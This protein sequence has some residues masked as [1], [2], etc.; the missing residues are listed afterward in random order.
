MKF[1]FYT[2]SSGLLPD[3]W[4]SN[5][6]MYLLR[7]L[8]W[9]GV[10]FLGL[11][12]LMASMPSWI[13]R[14]ALSCSGF[15]CSASDGT[16]TGADGFG[17]SHVRDELSILTVGD[18]LFSILTETSLFARFLIIMPMQVVIINTVMAIP[19]PIMGHLA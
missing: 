18:E 9:N 16:S 12:A 3:S 8:S 5:A 10:L 11:T 17:T 15:A 2:C 1:V 13:V 4:C 19:E 6:E 7:S 14:V